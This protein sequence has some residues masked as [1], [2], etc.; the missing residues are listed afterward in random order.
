MKKLLLLTAI[1]LGCNGFHLQAQQAAAKATPPPALPSGELVRLRAPEFARWAITKN[2]I[3][4]TEEKSLPFSR[5]VVVTKAEK[6]MREQIVDSKGQQ[7]DKWCVGPSQY[8][9][10]KSVKRYLAYTAGSF[11]GVKPN[12]NFYTDYSATD[13][14]GFEW[15]TNAHFSDVRNVMNRECIVFESTPS[16]EK[17]QAT[18]CFDLATRLPVVLRVGNDTLVYEFQGNPP[19]HLPLPQALQSQLEAEAKQAQ[20]KAR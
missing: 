8:S 17:E 16:E 20:A 10:D 19:R 12:P 14:P 3:K 4:P 1:A 18:A 15:V 7:Y 5:K 6:V 11:R 13:F 9:W 2:P